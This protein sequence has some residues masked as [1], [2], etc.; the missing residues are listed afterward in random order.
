M[1]GL[2]DNVVC[3]PRPWRT[4]RAFTMEDQWK[5]SGYWPNAQLVVHTQ[6]SVYA[7]LIEGGSWET[8]FT[9]AYT[10][11]S[12]AQRWVG[13]RVTLGKSGS[14]ERLVTEVLY[15][16]KSVEFDLPALQQ[17]VCKTYSFTVWDWKG[18]YGC[19]REKVAEWLITTVRRVELQVA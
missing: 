14:V 17:L 8:R 15:G 5:G 4:H 12:T 7:F 19:D 1:S 16:R 3:G 2:F 9:L 10:T 11:N 6:N 18:S 13:E